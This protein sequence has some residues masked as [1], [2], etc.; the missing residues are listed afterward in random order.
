[1]IMADRITLPADLKG[2]WLIFPNGVVVRGHR[3][4]T[5]L[6]SSA[7]A[8]ARP[9]LEYESVIIESLQQYV[10][11][12]A[13]RPAFDELLSR[14]RRNESYADAWAECEVAYTLVRNGQRFE[15]VP[16]R[17]DAGAR[18]P[19]FN[20]STATGNLQV[21]VRAVHDAADAVA[22]DDAA[23][24][25]EGRLRFAQGYW[26]TISILRP[27]T[28]RGAK[29]LAAEVNRQ[30]ERGAPSG[31]YIQLRADAV[32][33][34]G[35]VIVPDPM[36]SR[37]EE[38]ASVE[39]R[40][41]AG[42]AGG[43][44]FTQLGHSSEPEESDRVESAVRKKLARKQ[45][46]ATQPSVLVLEFSEST[47]WLVDEMRKGAYAAYRQ[48]TNCSAIVLRRTR[49]FGVGKIE[50]QSTVIEHPQAAVPID[51]AL[52]ASIFKEDTEMLT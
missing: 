38:I 23:A 14:L 6:T 19:D 42:D 24:E 29:R 41:I 30:I 11:R 45:F 3:Y 15:F 51:P 33:P 25:L 47:L 40:H 28:S 48:R 35:K 39:L 27:L 18:T 13:Q 43:V 21:E 9:I 17:S 52:I 49:N 1:M 34:D 4:E 12:T 32:D 31:T 8:L 7:P 37:Y 10:D 46:D 20:V 36:I 16:R 5:G 26:G 22:L 2:L 44:L 50:R